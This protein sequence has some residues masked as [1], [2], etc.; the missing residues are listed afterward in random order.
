MGIMRPRETFILRRFRQLA[1][2][3]LIDGRND[4]LGLLL[5]WRHAPLVEGQRAALLISRVRLVAGLFALLTPLW[6]FADIVFL[7]TE[8]WPKLAG[9]RIAATMA[10][11]VLSILYQKSDRLLHAYIALALLFLVPTLFFAYTHLL[12]SLNP[13]NAE[14]SLSA[15]LV[16]GYSFLPFVIAAGFSIFPLTALEGIVFSFP[17]FVVQLAASRYGTPLFG[18]DIHIGLLWLLALIVSIAVLSGMSQLH[19]LSEII[20]KTSHDPLTDGFNRATGEELLDKYCALAVRNGTSLTLVFIDLDH[21]KSVNDQYGH[22]AGDSVLQAAGRQL[23][24]AIRREDL[25]IRWGGE[26]FLVVMPHGPGD[27]PFAAVKRIAEQGLGVRPDGRPV[28]ASMGMADL[29]ADKLREPNALIRMADERMYKAKKYGRN[30]LCM[31][32]EEFISPFFQAS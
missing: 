16:A 12:F 3:V 10:F 14:G 6:I 5:P 19:F 13:Y 1:A 17:V 29:N 22:E 8:I 23:L 28:T 32:G 11:I 31:R 20:I 2:K 30:C 15:G 21:F 18:T 24:T 26:E 4:P 25:F 9:G 27:D 7:P